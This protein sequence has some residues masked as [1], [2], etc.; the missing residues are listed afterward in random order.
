LNKDP[1]ILK[2][3]LEKTEDSKH[4]NLPACQLLMV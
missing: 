4:K 2:V 3:V 1:R